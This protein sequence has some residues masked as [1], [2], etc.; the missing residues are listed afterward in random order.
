M[1]S[2]TTRRLTRASTA[3]GRAHVPN[4][5]ATSLCAGAACVAATTTV[6]PATEHVAGFIGGFVAAEGC[7]TGHGDR[8]FRFSVGLG[9]VDDGMC[10]LMHD[11]FSVGSLV[12][13]PRRKPHYDD[14][15]Q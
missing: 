12:R 2:S 4:P 5:A 13:S 11:V 7:F 8:R 6:Q 3:R 15:V 1:R 9:A 10:E 14:E